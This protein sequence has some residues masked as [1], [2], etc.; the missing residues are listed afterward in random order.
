MISFSSNKCRR[1]KDA[2]M[3]LSDLITYISSKSMRPIVIIVR[4][5]LSWS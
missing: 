2:Y 1:E 3:P 5:L 4:V